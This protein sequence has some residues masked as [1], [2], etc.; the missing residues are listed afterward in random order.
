MAIDQ[1]SSLCTAMQTLPFEATWQS[2]VNCV[3][4]TAQ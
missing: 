4:F 3:G 1:M 2:I